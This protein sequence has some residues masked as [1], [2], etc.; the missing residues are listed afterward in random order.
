MG[1][2]VPVWRLVSSSSFHGFA[3]E[4]FFKTDLFAVGG[5][6]GWDFGE[7]VAAQR[8]IF[9]IVGVVACVG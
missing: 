7:F 4:E 6:R 5:V 9:V 1:T 3:V 8:S 2:F